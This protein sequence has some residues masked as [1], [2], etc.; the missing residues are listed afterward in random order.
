M[1]LPSDWCGPLGSNKPWFGIP[2]AWDE[3]PGARVIVEEG[4]RDFRVTP[5]P[6][7][8]FFFQN[9]TAF[10]VGYFMVNPDLGKGS[11]D[12]KWLS[13]QSCVEERCCVRHLR[14]SNPYVL[15]NGRS[16]QGVIFKPNSIPDGTP[17]GDYFLD[18]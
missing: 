7:Q 13:A 10:P 11:V 8:P 12:W 18:I 5:S 3:I 14:F 2:V 17:E 4:F 15:T 1:L 9:L 16:S 6:R